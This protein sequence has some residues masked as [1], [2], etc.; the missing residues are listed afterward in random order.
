MDQNKFVSLLVDEF[1]AQKP[2]WDYRG[3]SDYMIKY[4]TRDGK[5][6]RRVQPEELMK[7]FHSF[8]ARPGMKN[9]AD[10]MQIMLLKE[11]VATLWDPM[12]TRWMEVHLTPET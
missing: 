6:V 9:H 11:H 8:R 12:I 2:R 1:S 7:A 5:A 3:L 10:R 4:V